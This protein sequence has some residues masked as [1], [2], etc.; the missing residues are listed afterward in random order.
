[1]QN[2]SKEPTLGEYGLTASTYDNFRNEKRDLEKSLSEYKK[3][4]RN[5]IQ[6][7]ESK[8][9]KVLFTISCVLGF[10]VSYF[11]LEGSFWAS[12]FACIPLGIIIALIVLG[13]SD[14]FNVSLESREIKEHEQRIESASLRTQ[15]RISDIKTAVSG[16]EEAS[17]AFYKNY[18]DQFFTDNLYKKRSGSEKF[19]KALSEFADMINEVEEINEK[20]IFLHEGT[21]YHELYLAGRK[22]NHDLQKEK[23][24]LFHAFDGVKMKSENTISGRSTSTNKELGDVQKNDRTHVVA[25]N[26]ENEPESQPQKVSSGNLDEPNGEVLVFG[27][28]VEN[29]DFYK[30]T[31]RERDS[32]GG[33]SGRPVAVASDSVK[34]EPVVVPEKKE[35]PPA[36]APEKKY[37]TARKIDNWEEINR[38]RKITGTKGEEIALAIEQE[39][40]ESIGRKDLADRVRHVSVEDGD[41]LGYDILSFFDNGKEKYIEVKSTTVSIGS[42]FNISK[43]ELEFL[44]EHMDNSFVCRV[45]VPG[46][47]VDGIPGY[48]MVPS[49]VVLDHDI[50][51][52]AFI[53][54]PKKTNNHGT[55][56]RSV[57]ERIFAD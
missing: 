13:L 32:I 24:Q 19:E 22:V 27:Q 16:F 15:G 9:E 57:W 20:L 44:R 30:W 49:Y 35:V 5:K 6:D 29:S 11:I 4:F 46:D 54:K 36:I 41:G 8:D 17:V 1:M 51:P 40:F 56:Q 2:Y 38:K 34:V 55:P 37:R 43:N 21:Y 25:S 10:L 18:L 12:I 52:T 26:V 33:V 31:P 42:P 3:T 14:I 39:Y 50:S 53:V 7:L 48:E 28:K 45:L 47:H 23:K